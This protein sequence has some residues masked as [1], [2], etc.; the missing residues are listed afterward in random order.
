MSIESFVHRHNIEH[1][2]KLLAE[3]TDDARRRQ[4]LTLIAEA[5]AKKDEPK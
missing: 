3:T 4:L 5:E 1:Y 2:R